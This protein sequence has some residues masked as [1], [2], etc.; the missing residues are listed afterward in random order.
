MQP[1]T[2]LTS[3]AAPLRME[4]VDTDQIIP[5]QYLTAVTKEG[6]GKGLFSW[7]RY[8]PD[9]TPKPDF[10]LNKPEYQGAQILI[11]GRNF[12]SGSSREHAVWALTDYGFR[13]VISPGFADIFYNNSLKNGLLPIVLPEEVVNLLWDLVEEEPE[14]LLHIDLRSQTVTLPDGQQHSF[15]IDP[16]RKL[17][18]LEGVDDLGYL[19][20][21]E[22]A[23]AAYEARPRWT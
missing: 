22:E 5:A 1:F 3:T 20:S 10:V 11:A 13:C 14:T 18:L 16:F 7:I 17:C 12:G 4:N 6:M 21:K 2:T 15:A 19:L 23:I 8:N 9:G